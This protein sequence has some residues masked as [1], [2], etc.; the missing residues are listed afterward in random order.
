[1]EGHQI[2]SETALEQLQV[3]NY[4]LS[5]FVD[6][7]TCKIYPLMVGIEKIKS[8]SQQIAVLGPINLAAID[9]YQNS[10]LSVNNIC[11][12]SNKTCSEQSV[13]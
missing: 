12:V 1:M 11:K 7:F 2:K 4:Q 3:K 8:I 13:R 6:G 5:D 9:E 10:K